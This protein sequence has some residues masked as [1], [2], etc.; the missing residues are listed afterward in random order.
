[1]AR[2]EDT[3]KGKNHPM[4]GKHHSEESKNKIREARLKQKIP[5]K[6]T[7]IELKIAQF[8][9]ELNIPYK[10]HKAVM[11]ITQPDF[12][13]E[14][15]ICLYCDGDYWHNLP[16]AIKRDKKINSILKFGGFRVI[17]LWEHEINVMKVNELN[18]ELGVIKI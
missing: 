11:G 1:M 14:P 6:F 13:I 12:F 2:A 9:K 4:H 10:T 7:S 8:L 15:N 3:W 16:I 5:T 18:N 17:R